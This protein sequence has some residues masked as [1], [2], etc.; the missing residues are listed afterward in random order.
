VRVCVFFFVVVVVV[1]VVDDEGFT[2]LVERMLSLVVFIHYSVSVCERER[3]RDTVGTAD[4]CIIIT[5]IVCEC[6]CREEKNYEKG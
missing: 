4:I 6:V 3:E 1:V 2:P 5:A